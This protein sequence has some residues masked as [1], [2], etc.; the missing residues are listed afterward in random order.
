MRHLK[1]GRPL[2]LCLSRVSAANV[3]APVPFSLL[4]ILLHRGDRGVC[5]SRR[6]PSHRLANWFTLL[7]PPGTPGLT[8]LVETSVTVSPNR[9]A[10]VL[11]WKCYRCG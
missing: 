4:S 2:Y 1:K 3:V 11:L 5:G 9:S 8:T 7:E 10:P 6:K